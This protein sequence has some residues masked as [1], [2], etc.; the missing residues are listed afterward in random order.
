[1]IVIVQISVYYVKKI[2]RHLSMDVHA[3]TAVIQIVK[4]VKKIRLTVY[5]VIPD[6]NT[7]ILVTFRMLHLAV[8]Q[9]VLVVI[10]EI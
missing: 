6:I 8:I 1:M 3:Q 7:K 9:N 4:L 5:F 10:K 2:M